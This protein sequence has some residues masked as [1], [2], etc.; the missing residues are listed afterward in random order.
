MIFN[1]FLDMTNKIAQ[2]QSY[3]LLNAFEFN[4]SD[5]DELRYIEQEYI[6]MGSGDARNSNNERRKD[7]IKRYDSSYLT[8]NLAAIFR[9]KLSCM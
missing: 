7:R 1:W 5:R 3:Y 8:I 2:N 4:A 6:I 9:S